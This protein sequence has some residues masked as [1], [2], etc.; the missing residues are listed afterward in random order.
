MQANMRKKHGSDSQLNGNS[1]IMRQKTQPFAACSWSYSRKIVPM[2]EQINKLSWKTLI[3][4]FEQEEEG[5]D[6]ENQSGKIIL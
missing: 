2:S 3:C 4:L 1:Q 6:N 5:S